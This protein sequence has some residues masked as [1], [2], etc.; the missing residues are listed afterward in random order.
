MKRMTTVNS[1]D[2]KLFAFSKGAPE[3]ILN[4][5]SS[6]TLNGEITQLTNELKEKVLSETSKFADEALRVLGLAYNPL[7]DDIKLTDEVENNLIFIGFV[8]MIDPPREEVKDSIQ[9]AENAGIKSIMITGDHIKTAIA[10]AKELKILSPGK[11]AIEGW[12]LEEMS[13]EELDNECENIEVY[14]RISPA[15]K[16]RI[17][18]TL[19]N[20]G[21]IVTMTGDGV[22]DAPA[23]KNADIGVAMGIKGT[24]VSREAADMILT[25]DNFSSIVAAIEEGRSIF[26][27]IRKYLVYLLSGNLGTIIA[28]MVSLL[29]NYPLPLM[30]VQVLFINFLM[31]GLIAIALSVEPAEPGIMNKKPRNV[32]LGILNRSTLIYTI[33]SGTWIGLITTSIFIWTV[34]NGY[35]NSESVTIF[36]VSLILARIFNGFVCRSFER[37]I[38]KMKFFGNVPLLLNS[39][40]SLL[41]TILVVNSE[42]LQAPFHTVSI[43]LSHWL[44]I[45]LITSSTILFV[46]FS[47]WIRNSFLKGF[48]EKMEH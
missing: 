26:E 34:E 18:K 24:D 32:K 21:Y 46:M 41:A 35:S 28:M 4:H 25:N 8:G 36:F 9:I 3:V 6:I 10:V 20:K 27:N 14:A 15:H 48:F 22:N 45:S 19:M 29:A 16:L 5:C 40:V 13:D 7:P 33:G 12:Q 1:I 38:Y 30:A 44:I 17:V 47:K 39:L 43:S 37:P 42:I 31:D 23:L 11:K 2:D